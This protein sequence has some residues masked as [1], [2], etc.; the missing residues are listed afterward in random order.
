MLLDHQYRAMFDGPTNLDIDWRT[1]PGV[2]L[3]L[4]GRGS[5]GGIP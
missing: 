5:D 4:P 2:V 1:S 3:N